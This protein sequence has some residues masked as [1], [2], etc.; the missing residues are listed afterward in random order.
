[1]KQ[2]KPITVLTE[3]INFTQR[4]PLYELAVDNF[5]SNDAYLNIADKNMCLLYGAHSSGKSAYLSMVGSIV[6]LAHIGSGVPAV[7]AIIGETDK[8]FA[9]VACGIPESCIE[10]RSAFT[11]DLNGVCTVCRTIS[12]KS[13]W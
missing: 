12:E 9:R 13:V 1:M 10:P 6:L 5:I 7:K 3:I 11:T 2:T 4:H 8:L